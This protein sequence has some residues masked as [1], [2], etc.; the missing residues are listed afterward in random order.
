MSGSQQPGYHHH[1]WWQWLW[2]LTG[3]GYGGPLRSRRTTVRAS[4]PLAPRLAPACTACTA[5]WCLCI[6]DA[7]KDWLNEQVNSGPNCHQFPLSLGTSLSFGAGIPGADS[8]FPSGNGIQGAAGGPPLA[9]PRLCHSTW[10]V[11]NHAD[12]LSPHW[13]PLPIPD[14]RSHKP[15]CGAFPGDYRWMG[16]RDRLSSLGHARPGQGLTLTP[17]YPADTGWVGNPRFLF[18]LLPHP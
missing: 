10:L 15:C 12:L 5:H 7:G 17:A 11:S 9:Q 6:V 3:D 4:E 1:L 16:R 2:S 14:N 18:P 8:W 13:K